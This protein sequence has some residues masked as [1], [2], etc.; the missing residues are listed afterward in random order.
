MTHN[1]PTKIVELNDPGLT[2]KPVDESAGSRAQDPTI[3]NPKKTA[4]K[5]EKQKKFSLK[6]FLGAA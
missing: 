3:M 1:S 2:P 6:P 5:A 4:P